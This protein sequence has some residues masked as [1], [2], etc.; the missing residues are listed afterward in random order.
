[1]LLLPDGSVM[2]Q[3]NGTSTDWARLSPDSTG[4]YING[5]WTRLA[6]MHNTR[7]YGASQILPNGNVFIAG[8]EYGTGGA[9]GEIYNPT[10]NS[11]AQ[12]P[13]QSFGNLLDSS[14]EMLPNGQILIAPVA[15]QGASN[16]ILFDPST[17][18]WSAGPKLYRGNNADEQSW[19]KLADGSILTID[20]PSTSE[21]FIPSSNKWVNDASV[22]VSLWDSI[23]EIGAGVLLADG[24]AFYIGASGHTALYTPSGTNAAG[25]WAKGPDVPSGGGAPDAPA[26]VLPDGTVLCAMGTPGT[27]NGPTKLYLYDPAANSFSAVSGA[28]SIASGPYVTRMLDLPD[29]S[30][31]FTTGGAQPYVYNAGTTPLSAPRPTISGVQLNSDGT[32]QL[33]GTQFNG[34]S[35]GAYYGDDAQMNSN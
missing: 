4:S 32:Y 35:E 7:L 1:M 9:T 19:V 25:S 20:S 12:L 34:D 30:V 8:A 14:S 5:T 33:S 10:T 28:P 15:P 21:R 23:G 26:A 31:L 17:N 6:P 24:R 29:G 22:P 11:W 16:T 2:A 27:Y 18:T 3:I 13:P